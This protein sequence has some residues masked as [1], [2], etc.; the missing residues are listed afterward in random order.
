MQSPKSQFAEAATKVALTIIFLGGIVW[1]VT[2]G[3][4]IGGKGIENFRIDWLDLT[5]LSFATFRLGR[6]IAYDRVAEP[7]RAPFTKTVR[8]LSGAGNTVVPKGKGVRRALGQLI[9]CPI[10]AG[11][12]VA[13]FLVVLMYYF[14]GPAHAFLVMTAAIGGAELIHNATEAFCWTGTVNR[15]R[16]G[17]I[18][19]D[20]SE[21]DQND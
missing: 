11:T 8:D 1:F 5:L 4:S 7:L 10:C 6:L 20:R 3:S 17:R 15:A 21:E 2:A 14:P 18:F 13:A 9:S 16:A 19:N 12:W